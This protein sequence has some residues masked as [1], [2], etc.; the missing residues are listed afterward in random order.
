MPSKKR[1]IKTASLKHER[2]YY[3]L[4]CKHIIGIDEAGRGPWAGPVSAGAV[5][6]PVAQKD[7]PAI[8]KGV[9]DSKQMTPLQREKLVDKIKE[10]AVVWGIGSASAAEIDDMG[11]VPATILAMTRALKSALEKADFTPD[12]LFLDDMILPKIRDINQVSM[13]EGDSRSM[14]IAAASV[15]A[16][17]W[18]DEHMLELDAEFP[19][20]GFAAHKGYGT[21]Q[22]QAALQQYGPSPFH[23][24]Y[25]R[26][27]AKYAGKADSDAVYDIENG[28]DT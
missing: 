23:R 7:L 12:C 11:I 18:R 5:C 25:Y 27:V 2:K 4:G 6:L 24:M 16:K 9:R 20:Y 21:P 17:T 22:H 3:A 1:E 26:P 28:E 15:L 8:L 10:A 13:I 19:R 14:S